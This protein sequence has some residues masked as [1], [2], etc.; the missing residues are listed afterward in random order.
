M[1]NS[2]HTVICSVTCG[3]VERPGRQCTPPCVTLPTNPALLY[4]SVRG[5]TNGT[6][7]HAHLISLFIFFSKYYKEVSAGEQGGERRSWNPKERV[8]LDLGKDLGRIGLRNPVF[9][10]GD[11]CME[12]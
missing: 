10:R 6:L 2:Y 8:D 11:S 9:V 5:Y 1:T 3:L 7:Q 12:D 4:D